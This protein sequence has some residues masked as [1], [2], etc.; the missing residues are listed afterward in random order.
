MK[1]KIASFPDD[2]LHY[3][4]ESARLGTMRAASEHLDVAPSSISRQISSL[5][6]EL[7]TLLVEKGRHS[8]QL[9]AAGGLLVE[10]YRERLSQREALMSAIDDLRGLRQGNLTVAVGQGLVRTLLVRSLRDFTTKYPGIGLRVRSV[11]WREVGSLVQTDEAHFGI[12]LDAPQ[13]PRIRTRFIIPQP[14]HLITFPNHAFAK[15]KSVQL[16]ELVGQR[17][18]L[19]EE[20]F[21]IGQI[22]AAAERDQGIFLSASMTA[23]S[24]QMLMDCVLAGIGLTIMPEACALDLLESGKLVAIPIDHPPFSQAK[25]HVVVRM[26]R[27]LPGAAIA[28][29]EMLE[30]AA[31]QARLGRRTGRRFG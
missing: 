12:M 27:Q 6:K 7:G 17:L 14:Y 24:I 28:L 15:R 21:R 1:Q 11:S 30:R 8:I 25:A 4:F 5:E 26:A 2:R 13:D 19:P 20:G 9:T 22:L 3:L 18:L 10:Y 23:S 31:G 16:K 29:L